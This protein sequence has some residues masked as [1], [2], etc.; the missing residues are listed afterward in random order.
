MHCISHPPANGRRSFGREFQP[1]GWLFVQDK[2]PQRSMDL[3]RRTLAK[4]LVLRLPNER[5]SERCFFLD[6]TDGPS[7][8]VDV[9]RDRRRTMP[10]EVRKQIG[11]LIESD[12]AGE[13]LA[14]STADLP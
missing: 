1:A 12:A 13:N 4:V 6:A 9:V 7:A 5:F 3:P 8:A 11:S 10:R 14:Q 2:I